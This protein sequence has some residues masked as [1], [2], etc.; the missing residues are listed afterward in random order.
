M[1][2]SRDQLVATLRL[3]A[4][5]NAELRRRHD[6]FVALASEPIAIVGVGCRFPGGVDSA[7]G[8]WEVVAGGRDVVSEF[9]R[10]RGWDVEGL[11]D[12]DPDAV[13]RTYT[14]WG[15]FVEDVAGFDAGF[16]G[17]TPGE[18]LAMDPQQR[19]LLE[20]AW[21]ALEDGGIDPLGLRGSATG[22]FVGIM[23]SEYGGGP[24]GGVEGYGL[25]GQAV[26]VASGRIAYVW[27]L[28]GPAVS[29]DT[30]CS[31]S[32]VALHLACRSLRSGECDL[33]LA[34]GVTVMASPSVF[35]G[36]ARQRGLAV[37][38][39]C[40]AFAGA[41]DGTGFGEGAGVVVLARLS[42]ARRR[43]YPVLAVV[44]GSAVNQDGASNGLTAPN[45][46]SQQRVIRAALASAG[47]GVGDVDV[48]EA[49][50]TGTTLGDPIE[51]QALLAT[52][53]QDRPVDQPLWLGSVKSNLGH[54]QAA[55]GVAG[56]IKMV[57]ALR[58]GV[59][60]ATLHVD[61]PTPHVDWSAG[62]VE[63]VTQA[64]PWPVRSG[65]PRRAGVSSFGISGTN[66]HVILE[67]APTEVVV[68]SVQRGGAGAGGGD[69]AWSVPGVGL[70]V[71]PW[72]VTAK[73]A[74][75]LVGQAARLAEFVG[76]HPEVDPVD[77]GVSL[78]RRS[79]FEHRAVV[80]GA[81]REQL[82]AGLVGLAG[83]QS[84]AGVLS[85]RAQPVG[86]TVLVFPGQGSQWLG[87]G[88]ELLDG[89]PVFAREMQACAEVFSEF[90]DWSLIDVLR[91][92]SGAPGLDRVDVV[93][94]VLFAVMVSLA[95][96][97]R[98]VGVE[99]DAVIGH[100]QGE[101][102][103]AYVAGVL[104][105]RQ[106]AQVVIVRS[107]LLRALAGS[108]GMV[109]IAC[110]G[111]QVAPLVAPWGERIAVAAVNSPSAVVVSGDMVA[112]Q[113]LLS[114]CEAQ[115]VRAR[116]LEVDY[117]SHSAQVEAIGAELVEA[118]SGI[119]PCSSQVGFIS[120]VTGEVIDGAELDGQYWYRNL[121]Q[122]VQFEQALHSAAA[123][124]YGVFIE[125][126]AHPVLLSAVEDALPEGGHRLG[127]AAAV[128]VPTLGRQ[129]GGLDR[130]MKSVAQAYAAG[131]GV[132]WSAVFAGSGGAWVGLPTYSFA[133]R[134]FW[135]MPSVSL[136]ADVC[137]L[138]LD[139][140]DHPVLGAVV[141]RAD[142]DEV[143]LTGRVSLAS[144]PWLADHV[145]GGV[146]VFPGA[147]LVELVISAGDQV[148]CAAIEELTLLA[149]LVLDQKAGVSVQLVLGGVEASGTRVVSVYSRGADSD[150]S[151]VLHAQGSL[152]ASVVATGGDWSLWPP[153][154]AAAVDVSGVYGWLAQRG[155]Q[156]GP[157][158]Q[159]LSAMWRLGGDVF[160]E[161]V[162]P[163]DLDVSGYGL[164]PALFD[165]A[166]HAAVFDAGESSAGMDGDHAVVL[167]FCWQGITLH[168][169]GARR[170]R[171]R[172]SHT[173]MDTITIELADTSGVPV[174]SVQALTSRPINTQ[175]LQTTRH[176][177]HRAAQGLLELGWVAISL[178]P[179]NV[180][181]TLVTPVVS[182]QDYATTSDA[183]FV[184]WDCPPADT[185]VPGS[186]YTSTHTA[187]TV[188]QSWL[189]QDASAVMIICT[190]GAVGLPGE[191]ITDLAGAAVWGLTRSAQTE[192]PGRIVLL[193]T[194]TPATELDIPVLVATAEPQLLHRNGT[195]YTARLSPVAE[196]LAEPASDVESVLAQALS[197]GAVLVSG[198]TGMVG[199][200]LARHV[201]TC[202]G[203][204]E[205][206]LVGRRGDDAA[207]VGALVA[208]LT[209]LGAR[210]RVV[211][212]DVADAVAVAGLMDQLVGEGVSLSAVIHAAGVLDDAPVASLSAERV[213]A[214]LR[215]KVDGAWNLHEVTKGAGLSA[216]VVCSSVA[217][218]LG[219]PGQANYGAANAFLDGLSAHRRAAGLPAISVQWGFWEQAS[220]MTAHLGEGECARM[221]RWALAPMSTERA[222]QLFD[223]A[224]VVDHPSVVAA[225]LDHAVLADPTLTVG[226]PPVC[227]GLVHRRL[228]PSVGNGGGAAESA[229]VV[230]L[231]GVSPSERHDLLTEVVCTHAAVVL[232]LADGAKIHPDRAFGD[233]GFDSLS[234]VEL[235]NR[236][237]VATGLVLPATLIFDYPTARVLATYLG[238]QL[239]GSVAPVPLP[240]PARVGPDEPI[241]IVGVGC[242]FPGGVDSA[243]GLWEVVAGGR[244]VVSEF[245]RDRGWDVEGLFDADPDAVG[246]TYTRWGGFVEDVAGFDAGFFGITPGEALAMDPQQRLL[247]E[248][249]WEALEDG[250]IDPLGLRGSATGVFVGIM[251]SEYGGGPAGGVEGYGL[252]G[253]AVSVASGR[254]AY[255]WGLEGPAVSVDTACSS[256]LVA[257]H[258]ACRSLRSGECDLALAAGV[259]VMASPSVFVGFARQR[260]LAVDG[261]CKAFA[262]AADGTG[263]GEGAG[264][265]VLARLSE[266]RRRGYPVLAVV[267]GSAVNQDGAS[268]GLTAPNGPS[269]QRVIRA[270][271]A[272]AGLGV[273]DVDV[274]EAHGTGT[275]LGDPIEAQALLATYGQDRPVDQ[276]LWLGS[277]KSNLGHTQAAAGVA[278]VIKMVQ[279]L[280]YGVIPATLHVDQPT[281]HVDWSAGAVELVTQA[282]PWPV[283]SGRPRRAGVSSFGISGTNAHVIL[284]EAPTEVVVGSVQ[285]GGAGAGGGDAAWS[286]PGVGLS[287][288]PWVVTAKSASA[289]VGQ[290]AR[291]AEFVGAHPEVDPVDVG[292]S[293]VRRSVFEHR[294]VVVGA[295]REQ[296]L[297]GLVGLAGGQSGAGVLSGR[298]Q[299]VGKTVL[300][301]PGQGSQWLGMGQQLY[302][303]VRVFAD[304]FDAVAD[305]LDRYLRLPLR[306]VVWGAGKDL[307]DSTEFAQPALFALEAALFAMLRRCGVRP[308]FVV[309]HSVGEL[310]AAYVTGVLSLADAAM[311]VA[312][313]GRLM[314]ALPSGGAMV[315]VGAG[316]AEVA[317]LLVE[318]VGIAAV[319]AAESVVIS[320]AQAAV[321]GIAEELARQGKRVRRLAVSHAFHSPLVEPMLE[322]FARV[323]A[324]ITVSPAQIAV[325]SNVTGE[326]ADS[327]FGSALY[328]VEH[329]RAPVRFADSVRCA[330]INGATHFIEV[331]PGAGLCAAINQSLHLPE[332]AVVVPLLG[333][334]R[335]EVRSVL[336]A[337]GQLFTSGVGVDWSAVFAGSGGAWVG[338]PTYSF[339]RRRF[340]SMPS[341]SLS[342]DVCGLGLDGLDHPV[343]GAVVARA[344][345]DEVVLTGRV[346][347]ASQP[348]LADH[349]VGGVVVFP[350]AGLVELVISAGDQVGCAAIEELTLLAPLVLDQ[351]A[352]VSVQLVL[353]G[354]E[355]SGTRVVSVYSRGADS[356]SSWVLH[357]QGSLAASVVATGGDW[358]LWPPVGAAAVDVSGVYGWLA[359]RGYQYGPAFQGL[360][361][362]WR[363]G[364]DVF[365]EVVVPDDLDVSGYGLH[366]A[367]FDAALHAAVFGAG[368]S[369]AGM[370]GDHAVVLPFC[371]QGI[372][373]HASGARRAR[374]RISHTGMDTITIEL[375]DTSGVPVLSVQALTS[376]PINTQQLNVG[377]GA[378][379]T[380]HPLLEQVWKPIPASTDIGEHRVPRRVMCWDDLLMAEA[381][382]HGHADTG[383]V[384]EKA[385]VMW[386]WASEDHTVDSVYAGTH[387]ALEVLQHW[388]V[389]DRAGVLVMFTQGAVGL[390]GEDVTDLAGAAV[391]GLTRSAQTEHPGRIV[392]LDTDTPATELDIPALVATAEP[393]LLHRNG[394]TYA[395][396]LSEMKAIAE[397]AE[398]SG[399]A[400]A[401]DPAGLV[402]RSGGGP[403]IDRAGAMLITGGTGM[404]GGVLARHVV[405]RYGVGEVLLVSRR[406]EN[407]PGVGELMADLSQAGARVRV[408]ACDVAD[409]SAVTELMCQLTQ[410][411]LPL[412]GV[413]HAAGTVD[414]SS[415]C[416][417]APDQLDV[418]LRA[419]VNGA[420]NLHQATADMG[421]S[422]FVLC[423][424][425]AGLLG[426]PG[427]A[428][429][430]AA[431]AYL[432]ALAAHRRSNGL[433]ATSLQ[434]GLWEQLSSVTAHL[435]T[436]DRARM[437]Q[438]GLAPMTNTQ[439]TEFFDSALVAERPSVIATALE[440]TS[441][442]DPDL[443]AGLPPLFSELITRPIRRIVTPP[444]MSGTNLLSSRLV[445]LDAPDQLQIVRELVAL[446]IADILGIPNADRFEST[447]ENS[448]VDSLRAL[449]I[450]DRLSSVTGLKLPP[451]VVFDH[452][453][454]DGLA[455]FILDEMNANER[456]NGELV[457]AST[458]GC[459]ATSSPILPHDSL[460][461]LF[462]KSVDE[463]KLAEGWL[464]LHAA[465]QLRP[466][467]SAECDTSSFT[468]P[469]KFADGPESPHLVFMSTSVYGGGVHNYA[470]ISSRFVNKRPVSVVPLPGFSPGEALPDSTE[471]GIEV[472]AR[473]VANA[474]GDDRIVLAGESSGGKFAYAL[475]NYFEQKGNSSLVGVALLDSFRHPPGTLIFQKE[476]FYRQFDRQHRLGLYTA[477]RLTAMTVWS[478]ML[479]QLY[480]GPIDT[481]VL[482]V[483]CDRPYFWEKSELGERRDILAEPWYSTQTVRTVPEDHGTIL[484]DG[485]EAAQALEEWLTDSVAPNRV[486]GISNAATCVV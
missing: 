65:R 32:L 220:A 389:T 196:M 455:R 299:P 67:E 323:A 453:S 466:R 324:D 64:R 369:S 105:L 156:Y 432:D 142:C 295:D 261:R 265:V 234:A 361:A 434:W 404:V 186:V 184:V 318:G 82:L 336:A 339:A 195:T 96:L 147:G 79:V 381:A 179:N 322:E 85:G 217:G 285:R 44:C 482:F 132:D 164:H 288:V 415:V 362:M 433:A 86:K 181:S 442:G 296:L 211:A 251:A 58:Y 226:L 172:I 338:L 259:T 232:G 1:S 437:L 486:V 237:K 112:L 187:L 257:L 7:E 31:S 441:L 123:Q 25:T 178:A 469:T 246:R 74:S 6:E 473:M 104:S 242:R 403:V 445:G 278:G 150:S 20:C 11:F 447:L 129:D 107:R 414:D 342:A 484:I 194:D 63:L 364:G 390:P 358:S 425:M 54:T 227:S 357:A 245:P 269:Q 329:V 255:V 199:G 168:A 328:W 124:G 141:A 341:V 109:S 144:Q 371:W 275:T 50:G 91:G 387:A 17:I 153:V 28:E 446:N 224:L 308:D 431:N 185:A 120:T 279:A 347:L 216:F 171:V 115:G 206:V 131:V 45:G 72:V 83:G 290:A 221:R 351:K 42:E 273:G 62:A 27:G 118:L 326:L 247:L 309:G 340:W 314:Q 383:D 53:G 75:A 103:A 427:Q 122:S 393:Q 116:R 396:R 121:R 174:L 462:K 271:L 47:L 66:A 335:S 461:A 398:S 154:G 292:V 236:L 254:I 438:A 33:A 210:V 92:V 316:E 424:S 391:W 253:Q 448:G 78:V 320:G 60:P 305:E 399:V 421:L 177:Q 175:Q 260:G 97:W 230:R 176:T 471:A 429:Y 111:H 325:V 456:S 117:A 155:Y 110:G 386:Q 101:I 200:V 166:L 48:V 93:Q 463:E 353:G 183:Q 418:V 374:V 95:G 52:Y 401:H 331:G 277:V 346:S 472:L 363:L 70:S 243:E 268:N 368:E 419:K 439:A 46:P 274:V 198:G 420:W 483:Q 375:A 114:C 201:V 207:G 423:S 128:A 430:A 205:V 55:A 193:D 416:A 310:T 443:T 38:G 143:V 151:W 397:V 137:G 354:V 149:P 378:E 293:L 459:G 327:D 276:P 167:P 127:S 395:A 4:K 43:G 34:A 476:F 145:V 3:S 21:E 436:A 190:H 231:R 219:A 173:G 250:G 402:I 5:E 405:T 272:S 80:V 87:M 475:A 355:A 24:A 197:V 356:D 373:L 345:C 213:D 99:P 370:D 479:T 319:N 409:R 264:V 126:S 407:A 334:E 477:T 41:A 152:A 366:P 208:E 189:S 294:A 287:V 411:C 113:E 392:L 413:I 385:V 350:G 228:R 249:A 291:L 98:S 315:A 303:Q 138:G 169:S 162:V 359:Q 108:G 282:R 51:A 158:F 284:E 467:F 180:D 481:K 317:P 365:A 106:A 163:D 283:R 136:S 88:V 35:V 84:G 313:R 298:A 280:R 302:S 204:G 157:A 367:L 12:A 102:A 377:T 2:V 464:L 146:V 458:D 235:R 306:E 380:V 372:T 229:L 37:D 188:I 39:R 422:V 148:G 352:G 223:T 333:K 218:L 61:Q 252:T 26:S 406:G 119:T 139:G 450:R 69:A 248:C 238:E 19:L 49:H 321:N 23:A 215:A 165:A 412:I 203:V 465:A 239:S 408:M 304:V 337:V 134:R 222:L 460:E 258:L 384:G 161:V 16:F 474:V 90:V 15:G 225:R 240:V 76:A 30:A 428:N 330:R 266:A 68:G 382:G 29:V 307:L 480:D 360:S 470:A 130:F 13:G 449:E 312:A 160:A 244:D 140:L 133:R 454:I 281:P 71:V 40:K 36:F 440:R 400:D 289:L 426:T 348:W 192:H 451:A 485:I 9:P 379:A 256:S 10:D 56:V 73:S 57:Q 394:T 468:G 135:S 241:A 89:A 202:Y 301:F 159:G 349:V 125:A 18:A 233:M 286:V 14:R 170:A 297:A 267:C 81:D 332:E 94:P 344:D 77:V 300:V 270:A 191:D 263:F 417:L 182:W 388:L 311:L 209:E 457:T 262:G 435:R 410:Q 452:N 8:L 59:I 212:C 478:E 343:L 100:S 444:R 214:V 376:R 22:V